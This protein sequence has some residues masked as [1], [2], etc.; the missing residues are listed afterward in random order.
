[1]RY[2]ETFKRLVIIYCLKYLDSEF[3][4]LDTKY[5]AIKRCGYDL[6]KED[7]EAYFYIISDKEMFN[8]DYLGYLNDNIDKVINTIKDKRKKYEENIKIELKELLDKN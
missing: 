3:V 1:M 8:R 4:Y 7:H 6:P 5:E 2:E